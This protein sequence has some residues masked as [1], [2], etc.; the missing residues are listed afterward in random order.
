[1]LEAARGAIPAGEGAPKLIAVTLLTSMGEP[2][3]DDVGMTGTPDEVVTRLARLTKKCG[4]D[5]VVCSGEEASAL[6]T[7]CG[8]SFTLVTPGIRPAD[9]AV[10]DQQRVMTPAAAIAAGANYLVVGRPITR[11]PD[12]LEALHRINTEIADTIARLA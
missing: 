8:T 6:R 9:A 5:G 7:L 11:A 2:D 4:L 1:M 3:L 12:P 10:N